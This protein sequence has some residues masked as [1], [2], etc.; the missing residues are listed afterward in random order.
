M[1]KSRFIPAPAGNRTEFPEAKSSKSVHPRAC[2]EQNVI[3]IRALSR[4]GSSPRLRGTATKQKSV[5]SQHR[6]IPAP[7]GNRAK[8]PSPTRSP[9]VHPRAC[10]EQTEPEWR[11]ARQSGSSPRLRGTGRVGP[12]TDGRGR[13]IPAPAGNRF[14]KVSSSGWNTV[15]PRACGEQ[16]FTKL[17]NLKLGGSSPRLRGTDRRPS[18]T[19]PSP[20]FIPAPAGNRMWVSRT[21][22][23]GPVH[24]R[25]CGEQRKSFKNEVPDGGSSPRLRGTVSFSAVC[26]FCLRFIPAPAGNR[27]HPSSV[28]PP[29]SV[30]PRACGEQHRVAL[31]GHEEAGSSPRLRGTAA[32]KARQPVDQRFIPAPAGNSSSAGISAPPAP[33]HPR[34]CGE[35][36]RRQEREHLRTGSSPRLRGTANSAPSP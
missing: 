15:H 7:A 23:N 5:L 11:D 35:Q 19:S 34:A 10:G 25:A 17:E 9:T 13:F 33:V 2:G 16:E 20:R 4:A 31:A 18:R 8:S 6:F 1:R 24:P 3:Q 21:F 32:A 30:H 12:R 28:M 36:L 14:Q 26:M 22:I 29:A 27:P